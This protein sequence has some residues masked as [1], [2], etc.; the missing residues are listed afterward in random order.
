MQFS[1][2]KWLILLCVV[3]FP[4]VLNSIIAQQVWPYWNVAGD[5]NSWIGFWGAYAG[6]IG[7]MIMAFIAMK[8]LKTNTEQLEIIKQQ[9]RPYLF[10]SVFILHQYNYDSN[11]SEETYF[12]RIENHGTQIAKHVKAK[13]VISD[14]SLLTD[15]FFKKNIESIEMASFS[16]PAK[17]EKNFVLCKAIPNFPQ[18]ESRQ[19]RLNDLRQQW[20]WIEQ[21]KSSSINA[22]LSCE[23]YDE[24][25][26]TISMNSIG[27]LPTTTVQILDVIHHD[28]KGL[29]SI[30]KE[31]KITQNDQT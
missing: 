31:S 4:F 11:R 26:E 25:H 22:T 18:Q 2:L 20:E 1:T 13:I 7:T 6:A 8:T 19:A 5:A 16:L 24:E 3:I 30:I 17:G 9:N 12:F 28:I 23:G 14:T 21:L 27:Y 15:T 10:C 29:A